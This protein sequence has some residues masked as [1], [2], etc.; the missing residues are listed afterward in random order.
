MKTLN[1][2]LSG[3]ERFQQRFFSADRELYE[4]LTRQGQS[5]RVMIIAC[6]DSRV[7]PA[8]IT[9]SDPG[10][11]F[12]VRNVANLVPPCELG[13]GYHGTSAAIEFA[14]STLRVEHVIVMGHTRCGGIRALLGNLPGQE[15]PTGFIAPW[16]SIVEEARR[17]VIEQLP[18]APIEVQA[19]ACEQ[20]AIRVSLQNLISFPFVRNAVEAGSLKLHGWYFDF[21][22]GELLRHSPPSRRFEVVVASRQ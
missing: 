3:F 14:V 6:C 22:R 16:M 4:R 2:L 7:D 19:S 9:D 5:P 15:T 18:D 13:G 1:E 17:E 8:I 12:V 11:L 20:A 21:E 10:D